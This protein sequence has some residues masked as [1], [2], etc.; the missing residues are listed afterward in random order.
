MWTKAQMDEVWGAKCDDYEE[1]CSCCLAWTMFDE[2][3]RLRWMLT[4]ACY[5]LPLVPR[6]A[7]SDLALEVA[8]IM[9][10]ENA[11]VHPADVLTREQS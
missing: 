2:I 4:R 9:A 10:F 6:T 11:T 3:E 5:V 8:A 7:G 1:N